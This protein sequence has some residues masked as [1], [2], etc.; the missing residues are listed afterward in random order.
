MD[1][2]VIIKQKS[3]DSF[4]DLFPKT[5]SDLVIMS[6]SKTLSETITNI[7][8]NISS[9]SKSLESTNQG[10]STFTE[11]LNAISNNLVEHK[12]ETASNVSPGHVK[13][14]DTLDSI[15][16][17]SALSAKQGKTLNDK[18]DSTNGLFDTMNGSITNL[19]SNL[20][21]HTIDTTIHVTQE[22]KNTW[23]GKL[24]SGHKDLA[25]SDSILGHIKVL[26]LLSSTDALSALSA[27]Q[28]KALNDKIDNLFQQGITRT[29]ENNS[30]YKIFPLQNG[31]KII[32]QGGS[33]SKVASP[34]SI[35]FPVSF[36]DD[37]SYSVLI[38]ICNNNAVI[39]QA[40]NLKTA[41]KVSFLNS[42]GVGTNIINWI[43]IGY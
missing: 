13:V 8:T 26:D 10:M 4:I 5:K 11:T 25:A 38:T 28:G 29:L 21:T 16:A 17:L 43:A 27:K 15:D 40:I 18:I 36:S 2:S 42:S 19:S 12:K 1:K 32:M 39:G 6:D 23:D 33:I 3:G 41:S 34:Y 35:T 31:N 37:N 24:D 22:N 20:N 30:W 14:I 9:V 7:D